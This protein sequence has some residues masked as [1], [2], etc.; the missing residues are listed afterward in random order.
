MAKKTIDYDRMIEILN[1]LETNDRTILD[2]LTTEEVAV[3]N[4]LARGIPD[5]E[6]EGL[7]QKSP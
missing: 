2:A 1:A 7:F 5:L 6:T 3:A 4:D